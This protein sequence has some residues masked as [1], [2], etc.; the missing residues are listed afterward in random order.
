MYFRRRSHRKEKCARES[1]HPLD[2]T[3]HH[4]LFASAVE[5]DGE[6]VAVYCR[7]VAVA[8]FLVEDAVAQREGGDSTGRFRHQLALDSQRQA[9]GAAGAAPLPGA[10]GGGG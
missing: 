9:A 10:P 1:S 2:K 6:L 4:A 5:S 8:E 7:D 3:I